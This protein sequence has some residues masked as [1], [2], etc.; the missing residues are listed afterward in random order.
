M[1]NSK[2]Q[3]TLRQTKIR[4]TVEEDKGLRRSSEK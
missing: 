3:T 2:N 4:Q 1:G